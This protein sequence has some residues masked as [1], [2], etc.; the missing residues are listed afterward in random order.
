MTKAELAKA[1]MNETG[2]VKQ[3]AYR[4]IKDAITSRK[5]HHNKINDT[6]LPK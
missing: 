4:K 6:Y 2:C 3:Y 5:L 1:V